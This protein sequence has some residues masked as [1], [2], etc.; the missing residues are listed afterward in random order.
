MILNSDEIVSTSGTLDF[1]PSPNCLPRICR[2]DIA[3]RI[4][5]YTNI[6]QVEMKDVSS[7]AK[8]HLLIHFSGSTLCI[9]VDG[10]ISMVI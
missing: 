1:Q 6:W 8:T 2:D 4:S 3:I 7:L 10:Q 9:S 5:L